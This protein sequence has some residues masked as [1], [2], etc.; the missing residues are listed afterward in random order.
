[1]KVVILAGGKGTR[2]SEY[3][4][5][6]PK[7]M[8]KIGQKPII[9]HIINHYKKYDF[10][11]F[12]IAAGYKSSILKKYFSKKKYSNIKVVDT[13]KETLTGN[14]IKKLE[15]YLKNETFMLTYGDGLTNLN[16]KKLFNF[17]KKNK[18]ISTMTI[19]HPPA[20][21]GEVEYE[22]RLIKSFKE[23]PQLQKGWINGGYFVFE[24]N[25]FK[26]L[27]NKNIMLERE[28]IQ[29]LVKK[30][31]L[32]A[33]KHNSFWYCMDNLRDKEILEKLNKHKIP[34]WE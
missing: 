26:I 13:G 10:N 20:R 15:K 11:E 27:N 25:F 29:K 19:V 3:T 1:M 23:K 31:Q 5:T 8:I 4:K 9:E 16:L 7:P 33:F 17:H 32:A 12:I 6:I 18:K 28:P 24:P 22:N 14:R 30:K 21:F 2:I 34:P